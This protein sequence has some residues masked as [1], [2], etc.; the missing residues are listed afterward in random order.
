MDYETAVKQKIARQEME[1][2]LNHPFQQSYFTQQNYEI[3]KFLFWNYKKEVD[4]V[5][6]PTGLCAI[7][8]KLAVEHI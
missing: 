1:K 7:C 3:H 6:I 8:N 5:V 2:K 4:K